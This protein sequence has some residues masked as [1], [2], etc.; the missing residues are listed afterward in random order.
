MRLALLLSGISGVTVPQGVTNFRLS[1]EFQAV[2][3]QTHLKKFVINNIAS[4][5]PTGEI[6]GSVSPP[7]KRLQAEGEQRICSVLWV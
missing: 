4:A 2:L 5:R 3:Q 7:P 1:L 6:L